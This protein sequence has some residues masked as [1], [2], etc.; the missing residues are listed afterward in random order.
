MVEL[1]VVLVI[2][3]CARRCVTIQDLA[4]LQQRNKVGESALQ[5]GNPL[6]RVLLPVRRGLADS[7]GRATLFSETV[8]PGMRR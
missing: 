5:L 2:A 4:R 1:S 8:A 6:V 3:I 7:F